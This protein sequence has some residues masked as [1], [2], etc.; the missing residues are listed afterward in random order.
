M[1]RRIAP[2][3]ISRIVIQG[4]ASLLVTLGRARYTDAAKAHRYFERHIQEDF[5]LL[6]TAHCLS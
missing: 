4:I 5:S 3:A 2:E 1:A 6:A